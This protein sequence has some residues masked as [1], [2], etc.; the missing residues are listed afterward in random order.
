MED[1]ER[2]AVA[3]EHDL[4]LTRHRPMVVVAVDHVRVGGLEVGQRAGAATLDELEVVGAFGERA[5]LRG[6]LRLH[7]HER[8]V[9]RGGPVEKLL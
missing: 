8:G 6:R 4:E 9:V 3:R 1:R 7:R 2:G 5:D